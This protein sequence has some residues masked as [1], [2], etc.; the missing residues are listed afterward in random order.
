MN[1]Y[2]K[3][4]F[5]PDNHLPILSRHTSILNTLKY[6]YTA[7]C[8]DNLK[9]RSI[10]QEDILLFIRDLKLQA[11]DIFEYYMDDK[12]AIIKICYRISYSKNQDIIL[13]LS[14]SKEI[15][16]IYL[17]SKDDEHITLDKNL[18]VRN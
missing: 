16:T 8:L 18:Y 11:S 2:H 13:I 15:I 5:I 1:R 12:N 6:R 4:V 10:R 14:N 3:K 9:Y 17:N 7:H